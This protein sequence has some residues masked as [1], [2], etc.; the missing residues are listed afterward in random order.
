MDQKL[1]KLWISALS[2]GKFEKGK[3]SLNRENKF[4]CLGVLCEILN[5]P[6]ALE[7]D[8]LQ[9]RYIHEGFEFAGLLFLPLLRDIGMSEAIQ[10]KLIRTNDATDNFKQVIAIIEE[11]L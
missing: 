6:K 11:E 5:L 9:T 2:S 8:D 10:T 3:G 4:C 1:K 7:N